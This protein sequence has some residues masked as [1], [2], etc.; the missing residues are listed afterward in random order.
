MKTVQR[1]LSNT[2]L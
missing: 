1:S 2:V